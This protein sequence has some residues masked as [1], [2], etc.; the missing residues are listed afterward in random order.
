[1]RI[2]VMLAAVAAIALGASGT[3]SAQ[4]TD[5]PFALVNVI[6]L[7][8]F[9]FLD[10]TV[11]PAEFD[12]NNPRQVDPNFNPFTQPPRNYAAFKSNPRLGTQPGAITV[13]GDRLWIGGFNNGNNWGGTAA[14]SRLAWYNAAGVGEVENIYLTSGFDGSL[15]TYPMAAYVGPTLSNTDAITG[16][17]YDPVLQRVYITY[18]DTTDLFPPLPPGETQLGSY[19]ASVDVDP[20]SAN[21]GKFLWRRIDPWTAP[22]PFFGGGDRFYGGVAVDPLD[23]TRVYVAQNGQGPDPNA[24]GGFRV[25]NVN[26]PN[27]NLPKVNVKDPNSVCVSSFYRQ[28]TFDAVSGD[29]FTRNANAADWIPR[30][31]RFGSA[32]R[33]FSYAIEEPQGPGDRKA[34]TVATGDDVQLV[35]LNATTTPG[36]NI[37][38]AGPNGIID[39]TP[40][41]DDRLAY[42]EVRN[43]RPIGNR[44]VPGDDGDCD[45]DPVHGY[46]NG[47]FGQGQ[48]IAVVSAVNLPNL[49]VDLVIG[50]N[51][52]TFGANLPTDIGVFTI[53]GDYVG[54]IELPCAPVP[55]PP[56]TPRGL[57][58][59]DLDYDETT[60]TLV[61]VQM[62][63]SKVYVFQTE[64]DG[65]PNIPRY[66]FTRN[67]RLD[68]ADFAGFQECFTGPTPVDPLSLNCHRVN[69]DSDCDID[70]LDFEVFVAEWDAE[71]GA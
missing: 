1:M 7:F 46:P 28:I 27:A 31:T 36:Q 21:Y 49:D 71:F 33:P 2:R 22:D 10:T 16:M 66:D 54:Q 56:P 68:L 3:A 9:F 19:V 42:A 52:P 11:T 35:A 60:G 64:I 53:D 41:G 55:S 65:G 39:T 32:Y 37:I 13:H 6:D 30:D 67:L 17:D 47:P 50:N 5:H 62:E 44:N 12:P 43:F 26:D 4:P 34:N 48:G 70:G 59:Y 63:Q 51:R 58:I 29:M 20:N 61:I 14:S 18:D 8:D 69:S 40:A 15:I 38:G 24:A 57:S 45:D 23:P 25:I